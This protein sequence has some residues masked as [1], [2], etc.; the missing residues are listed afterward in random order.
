MTRSSY[1]SA[2]L[3]LLFACLNQQ[4]IVRLSRMSKLKRLSR[5]TNHK[6]LSSTT[7]DVSS[8]IVWPLPSCPLH[9][10]ET[11]PAFRL[12]ER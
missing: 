4:T 2:F 12:C 11:S 5:M 1:P 6:R 10:G 3:A 9:R 8:V 7:N